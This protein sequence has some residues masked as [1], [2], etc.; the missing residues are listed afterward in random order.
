M[1]G[2]QELHAPK[3]MPYVTGHST[4]NPFV[5]SKLPLLPC[6]RCELHCLFLAG[7]LSLVYYRHWHSVTRVRLVFMLLHGDLGAR[8]WF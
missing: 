2:M 1:Q 7:L 5:N 6:T 4:I 3:C 8:I